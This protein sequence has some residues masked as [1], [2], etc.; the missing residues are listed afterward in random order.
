MKLCSSGKPYQFGKPYLFGKQGDMPAD[1][2]LR[3][4]TRSLVVWMPDWPVIALTRDGP[5]PLDPADPIAV[6]EKN[7][8]IACSAAARRGGGFL[9]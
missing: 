1:S 9:Q 8:V 2:S 3:A 7:L 5:H 6:V 4:P